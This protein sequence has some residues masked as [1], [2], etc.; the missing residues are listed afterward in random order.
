[1]FGNTLGDKE[2]DKN[3]ADIGTSDCCHQGTRSLSSR[4]EFKCL[5]ARKKRQDLFFIFA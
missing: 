2:G 1:M 3:A 4:R 5:G